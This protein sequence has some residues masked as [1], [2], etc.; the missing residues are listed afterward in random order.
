MDIWNAID[1]MKAPRA[2]YT[3]DDLK[4]VTDNFSPM[5]FVA[6]G[7]H[8]WVYHA[9]VT[10][11]EAAVK[12]LDYSSFGMD[13]DD[14]F[15]AQV[16]VLFT[17][18]HEH[19]TRLMG[20]CMEND[21][22]YLVYEFGSLGSLHDVLHGRKGIEGAEPGPILT[23]AQRAKI[24]YG[25]AKGLE[26]L[27][28]T[29]DPPIVHGDVRSSNVLLFY[30]YRS[31]IADFDLKRAVP[32]S[33]APCTRSPG[34]NGYNGPECAMT[35]KMTEKSDVY[36]F[37]VILLELLTGRKAVDYTLPKGQQSLVS[38][39]TPFLSADKVEQIVDPKL[40]GDFPTKAVAKV[41]ALAELCIQYEPDFRP[42]MRI[43]V[44]GLE[45]LQEEP[46]EASVV[47]VGEGGV[48]VYSMDELNEA[49]NN[50]NHMSLIAKSCYAS[51][52]R[53][54]YKTGEGQVTAVKK[55]DM[56]IAQDS[57]ADF[58][59]QLSVVSAL[60]DGNLVELLGYCLEENNRILVYEFATMGSL[61]DV[62]Y[63]RKQ[64]SGSKPGPD[65]TWDQRARIAYGAAKG[66][67]YLHETIDP[68]IV[69]GGVRSSNVLLFDSLIIPPDYNSKIADFNLTNALLGTTQDLGYVLFHIVLNNS[70]SNC[71]TRKSDI[72]DF[73]VVLLELLTG[74][75]PVDDT[76][77]EEQRDLVTWATPYLNAENVEQIIDAK[78]N[79]DFPLEDVVKVAEMAGLCIQ[80][81]PDSR[82]DMSTVAEALET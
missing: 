30:D 34:S 1:G 72:Y 36:S 8:A 63:G 15:L 9:Q 49:T 37:G 42:N 57:D 43:M 67:K 58:A 76:L 3:L 25:A 69:H 68:P 16:N 18:Q 51:V 35:G 50:F 70:T 11:Q 31:K 53:T 24:A 47:A 65:L 14:D 45:S 33:T 7:N 82:P 20:Y 22:R 79:G 74:R 61:H 75:K 59:A 12:K 71:I 38:W 44:M 60:K 64:V 48:K 40:N 73:G 26:Y 17:L 54:F 39:A 56:S 5:S 10:W 81:D 46:E 78:L 52:F 55:L 23:W 62:L 4:D 41:A 13:S 27:H 6:K 66:L 2:V 32:D 29:I 77:P 21:K 28:E 19:V 80:D